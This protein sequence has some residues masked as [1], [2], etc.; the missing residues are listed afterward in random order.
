MKQITI[1]H[2]VR[3]GLVADI[4]GHLAG[5]NI[6]IES[7]EAFDVHGWDIVQITVDRYDDAL[8]V[9]RDAGYDAV[10]ED[11]DVL[12]VKDEP[13]ALAKVTQRLYDAKIHVHSIRILE[14]RQGT[15]VVALVMDR[16]AAS[17]D[18]IRD[19][20]VQRGD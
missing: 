5:A 15:A 19:L 7:L 18:L 11:A 14:R 8:R 16:T 6:N 4:A 1:V 12:C 9:L 2:P 13:G 20:V 10:T 3:D 17:S